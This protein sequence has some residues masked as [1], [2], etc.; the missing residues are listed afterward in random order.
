VIRLDYTSG[1]W[2]EKAKPGPLLSVRAG[3]TVRVQDIFEGT[4]DVETTISSDEIQDLLRFILV[5][6]R[7]FEIDEKLNDS[8]PYMITDHRSTIIG[9]R[10]QDRAHEISVYALS[11]NAEEQPRSELTRLEAIHR[12]LAALAKRAQESAKR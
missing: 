10:L 11:F 7:F 1:P 12:R 2:R 8:I 9:V 4:P 3:G 5:E 6:N